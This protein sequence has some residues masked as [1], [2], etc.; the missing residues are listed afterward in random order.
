MLHGEG[1]WESSFE[2][3]FDIDDKIHSLIALLGSFQA[4]RLNT[5]IFR[6]I[7]G[8]VTR[9]KKPT[10]ENLRRFH[11]ADS[12]RRELLLFI[13]SLLIRSPSNRKSY[14]TMPVQF[15]MPENEKIV[16]VN[17]HQ[18]FQIAKKLCLEG[19]FPLLHFVILRSRTER[20]ITGDGYLDWLTASLK[21]NLVSG[22]ALLPL[23]PDLCVYICSLNSKRSDAPDCTVVSADPQMVKKVNEITQIHSGHRLF[24]IGKTPKLSHHFKSGK[25]LRFREYSH[26]FIDLMDNLAGRSRIGSGFGRGLTF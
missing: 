14:E 22:R 2:D 12:Q 26:P 23:T 18:D 17:I 21:G 16:P 20:F 5:G 25:Y 24:Y 1:V 3:S 8:F 4:Q 6:R 15:G 13:Y 19:L 10:F 11:I 9:P 7:L